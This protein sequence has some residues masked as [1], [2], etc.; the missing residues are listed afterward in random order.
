[1][2]EVEATDPD[3]EAFHGPP[4]SRRRYLTTPSREDPTVSRLG[5]SV[6]TARTIRR[7]VELS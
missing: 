7:A 3:S 5:R 4:A 6:R 2:E 1:M